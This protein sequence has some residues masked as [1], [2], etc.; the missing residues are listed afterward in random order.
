MASVYPTSPVIRVFVSSTF[1]DMQEERNFLVN[2][3][4]PDIRRQCAL[5]G[6]DFEV[7]DLRW[8]VTGESSDAQVLQYCLHQLKGCLPYLF[9]MIGGRYGWVPG[10]REEIARTLEADEIAC[11]VTEIEIRRFESSV[12]RAGLTPRALVGLRSAAFTEELKVV[13]P[14]G[15]AAQAGLAA[16]RAR[17]APPR[18]DSFDYG[19][20]ETLGDKVRDFFLSEA[21]AMAAELDTPARYIDAQHRQYLDLQRI[22]GVPRIALGLEARGTKAQWEPID[23]QALAQRLDQERL[24]IVLGAAGSGKTA[25]C[26]ALAARWAEGGRKRRVLRLHIGATGELSLNGI[27]RDLYELA[28]MD[29]GE[30]EGWERR[31]IAALDAQPLPTLIVLDG[32]E[33]IIGWNQAQPATLDGIAHQPSQLLSM[34]ERL[35]RAKSRPAVLL[36]ADGAVQPANAFGL[37]LEATALRADPYAAPVPFNLVRILP[38]DHA[39]RREFATRFFAFRGKSLTAP[40]F[41]RIGDAVEIADFDALHLACDR[42]RRFGELN[43]TKQSQDAFMSA[44]VDELFGQSRDQAAAAVVGEA[45]QAFGPEATRVE[46]ALHLLAVS[47]YGL[48]ARELVE[49]AQRYLAGGDFSLRD[50]AMLE[51]MLGSFLVRSGTRFQYKN[52]AAARSVVTALSG[53]SHDRARAALADY[54]LV[55]TDDRGIAGA[56]AASVDAI[57]ANELALQLMQLPHHPQAWRVLQPVELLAWFARDWEVALVEFNAIFS[58]EAFQ[59]ACQ[60]GSPEADELAMI[61]AFRSAARQ[62]LAGADALTQE[63]F[64]RALGT[65]QDAMNVYAIGSTGWARV[66]A[67]ATVFAF[68]AAEVDARHDAE[69]LRRII[70]NGVALL[71]AIAEQRGVEFARSSPLPDELEEWYAL[72]ARESEQADQ[73][74][75]M[76]MQNALLFELIELEMGR[77]RSLLGEAPRH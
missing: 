1:I 39:R 64:A 71:Q 69:S 30:L 3:V 52:A 45:R 34:I 56:L 32:L 9:A 21:S 55:R 62:F 47:R 46:A 5:I 19:D 23:E 50:W 74:G 43:R 8:G 60:A 36:A 17:F 54:L 10:E 2:Q 26:A 33:R 7:I 12:A 67:C 48:P 18:P 35:L 65:G 73:S 20:L 59:Q 14:L 6:I 28:D 75:G 22:S 42:L 29:A 13:E 24:H 76:G 27:L 31:L 16:L 77:L 61:A 57:Y 44:K 51:G 63:R 15:A 68:C 4:F 49:V 41:A 58:V 72:A 66:E 53:T 38:L 70:E 40:Q 11:S 37:A 25:L